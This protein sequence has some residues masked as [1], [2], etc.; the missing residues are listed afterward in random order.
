MAATPKAQEDNPSRT[1]VGP[2][3]VQVH[4]SESLLAK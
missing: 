3:K 4:I 2:E 1:L